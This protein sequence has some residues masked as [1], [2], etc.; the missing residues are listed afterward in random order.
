MQ[1]YF[2]NICVES[3]HC[4]LISKT[5]QALRPISH[6][7]CYTAE[8]VELLLLLRGCPLTVLKGWFD[9]LIHSRVDS[10][11]HLCKAPMLVLI[12][13]LHLFHHQLRCFSL[14]CRAFQSLLEDL[15]LD[16]MSLMSEIWTRVFAI[17]LIRRSAE[18]FGCYC[19]TRRRQ[20]AFN[21]HM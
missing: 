10:L 4:W 14:S 6:L 2:L 11:L 13:L 8:P 5:K 19:L 20:H 15:Y 1:D 17:V 7:V 18:L 12:C 3:K 21:P 9:H 16:A